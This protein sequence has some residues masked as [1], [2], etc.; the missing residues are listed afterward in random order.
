MESLLVLMVVGIFIF[1]LLMLIHF[2]CRRGP[3][4]YWFFVILFLGPLGGVFYFVMEV[5]PEELPRLLNRWAAH[6]AGL[7]RRRAAYKSSAASAMADAPQQHVLMQPRWWKES[8]PS[9]PAVR[10][11]HRYL[12]AWLVFMIVIQS[13]L[14]LM[15]MY[16]LVNEGML[17]EMLRET[18][19]PL[20]T[21][22]VFIVLS[23]FDLVCVF[24]L[25]QWKKWGFWGLCVSSVV[26]LLVD[27]SISGFSFD[28]GK[29]LL[30]IVCQPVSPSRR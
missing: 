2:C 7:D 12:T 29:P 15:F 6:R 28:S 13:A 4:W 23:L 10:K 17:E 1:Q 22:P 9:A 14:L 16:V 20:W 24:A 11:R 19:A 27:G 5:I 3:E 21:Y 18:A 25:F 8:A 30:W 26:G